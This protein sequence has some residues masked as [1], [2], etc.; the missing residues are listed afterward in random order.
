M[1]LPVLFLIPARG[2]SRR[3]PGKNLKLVAG[4]PLVAHAVRVARSAARIVPDGPHAVI[5]TT[6]DDGIADIA[7]V[8]GALLGPPA[9]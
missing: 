4:I 6:D 8:C 2:G 1:S 3:I 7:D 9:A 5:V